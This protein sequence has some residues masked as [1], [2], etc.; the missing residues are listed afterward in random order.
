MR[1]EKL[2]L[3]NYKNI[4]SKSFVFKEN[5]ICM[6]GDNGVGKSNILSSIYHLCFGKS[7]INS[8]SISNIKFGS[9]FYMIEGIFIKN[10]LQ[11]KLNFSHKK[12]IQK[13]LKEMESHLKNF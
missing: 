1:L 6:V 8:S 5:I 12:E 10:N 9:K 4:D 11:E 13:F 3:T 7:F 2:S